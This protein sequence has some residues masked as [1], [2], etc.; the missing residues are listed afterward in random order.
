MIL[1]Y[2]CDYFKLF[3]ANNKESASWSLVVEESS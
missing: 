2:F 3:Q 1:I